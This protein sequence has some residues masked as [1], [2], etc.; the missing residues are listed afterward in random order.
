[1]G[2]ETLVADATLVAAKASVQSLV[3]RAPVFQ[4]PRPPTPHAERVCEDN[5]GEP[6]DAST[7]G[8][9]SGAPAPPGGEAPRQ[10]QAGPPTS[11]RGRR[12]TPRAALHAIRVSRT[13]P[14]ASR[15]RRSGQGTRLASK[16]PVTVD[17]GHRVITA[18]EVAPADQED[19]AQVPTLCDRRPIPPRAVCAASHDG[20]PAVDAE[21]RRRGV[22]PA[23]PRRAPQAR[24]PTPGR[25]PRS[26]CSYVP[27]RDVSRCPQGRSLRRVAY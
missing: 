25:R 13:D 12:P 8:E 21:L 22:R 10:E 18:V 27:A 23:R 17:G 9:A 4:P 20:G 19:S 3:P 11:R 24:I 5:P 14:D 2:G 26:A 16:E 6:S 1:M 15:T 7:S